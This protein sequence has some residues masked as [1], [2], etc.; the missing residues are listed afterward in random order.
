[1]SVTKCSETIDTHTT[2]SSIMSSISILKVA[3]NDLPIS[4]VKKHLTRHFPSQET[5][6]NPKDFTDDTDDTDA[7]DELT[8]VKLFIENKYFQ[9]DLMLEHWDHNHPKHDTIIRNHDGILL[10]FNHFN[11]SIDTLTE[12]HNQI[13]HHTTKEDVGD[14]LRLCISTSPDV[15]EPTK[16]NEELYSQRVLWCLDR[17]YEYVEVDLSEEGMKVRPDVREKDGFDRVVEAIGSTVWRSAI[18]K[19]RNVTSALLDTAAGDGQEQQEQQQEQHVSVHVSTEETTST[20]EEKR[21]NEEPTVIKISPSKET[22][23]EEVLMNEFEH[24]MNEA[25]KIRQASKNGDL[26]DQERRDRAGNAAQM[27]MGLLDQMG[28]DDDDYDDSSGEE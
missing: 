24:L 17:G 23:S 2:H 7:D 19:H 4:I 27:L 15:I 16:A 5:T 26:S 6:V 18:M 21:L 1:M 20:L 9:A 11:T 12:I 10:I 14:A 25:K 3:G 8:P 22:K 13:C 28:F